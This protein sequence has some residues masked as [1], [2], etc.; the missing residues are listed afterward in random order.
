MSKKVPQKD[1]ER[2]LSYHLKQWLDGSKELLLDNVEMKPQKPFEEDRE[3]LIE[4]K[5]EKQQRFEKVYD[6]KRNR[7]VRLFRK[8][9][10]VFSVL[11]CLFLVTM[12]LVAVS[13]LPSFGNPSNPV[14]NEV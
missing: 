2:T 3:I 8:A 10:R 14:N 11:F 4:R 7:E 5:K 12:L 9:Y 6:F 1:Y 13:N